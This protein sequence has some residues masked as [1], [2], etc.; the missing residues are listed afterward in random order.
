MHLLLGLHTLAKELV[1]LFL[2]V[3]VALELKTDLLNVL[4][5]QV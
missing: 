3:L 5:L 4:E 1:A 2:T